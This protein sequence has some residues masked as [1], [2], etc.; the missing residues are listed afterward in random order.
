MIKLAR[1]EPEKFGSTTYKL[2]KIE[3]VMGKF[4]GTILSKKCMEVVM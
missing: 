1:K 4:E 2:K 3:K